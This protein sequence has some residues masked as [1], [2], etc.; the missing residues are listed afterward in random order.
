LLRLWHCCSLLLLLLLL[1]LLQIASTRMHT[2]TPLMHRFGQLILAPPSE[3]LLCPA[4][5]VPSLFLPPFLTLTLTL[6]LTPT[7]HSSPLPHPLCL[8]SIS[9][10]S[11]AFLTIPFPLKKPNFS[12]L[13]PFLLLLLLLLIM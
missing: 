1:L 5:L 13:P 7:H 12:H 4:P 11:M 9:T 3:L 8:L 10:N 2:R 6:T